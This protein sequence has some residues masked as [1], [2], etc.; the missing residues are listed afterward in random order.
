MWI[1]CGRIVRIYNSYAQN[2]SSSDPFLIEFTKR[3]F[4]HAQCTRKRR[5]G[6]VLT[7]GQAILRGS[8]ACDN[9]PSLR[10]EAGVLNIRRGAGGLPE[11]HAAS[12]A[13]DRGG[14][15][16]ASLTARRPFA[17]RLLPL[18]ENGRFRWVSGR[19]SAQ[20]GGGAGAKAGGSVCL[21]TASPTSG[22]SRFPGCSGGG[23]APARFRRKGRARGAFASAVREGGA[24]SRSATTFVPPRADLCPGCVHGGEGDRRRH[25]TCAEPGRLQR[26]VRSVVSAARYGGFPGPTYLT[27]LPLPKPSLGDNDRS[28][29]FL[30]ATAAS[31]AFAR[32]RPN[33]ILVL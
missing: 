27:P 29:E 8:A 14:P 11:T 19:P 7:S 24:T 28:G 4:H 30:V 26:G 10:G 22:T 6:G 5:R 9:G 18:V 13:G 16:K 33:Y 20:A 2:I 17:G 1:T 25:F 15:A 23:S 31:P 3:D 12:A 21:Q 32:R